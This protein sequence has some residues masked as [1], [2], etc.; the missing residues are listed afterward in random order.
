MV[1]VSTVS[2][3]FFFWS[4]T[5]KLIGY[6]VF[7]RHREPYWPPKGQITTAR[8]P[9]PSFVPFLPFSTLLRGC[10][11]RSLRG[12]PYHNIQTPILCPLARMLRMVEP[13]F[14]GTSFVVPWWRP[15]CWCGRAC[16]CTWVR[17]CGYCVNDAPWGACGG[18]CCRAASFTETTTFT[19]RMPSDWGNQ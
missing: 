14:F 2:F 17:A 12:C 8:P 19:V 7:S 18:T 1:C 6:F 16:T 5:V 10:V 11:E 4:V 3:F 9:P 15:S 13:A